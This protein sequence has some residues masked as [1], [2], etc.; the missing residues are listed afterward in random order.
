MSA[1]S[2]YLEPKVLDHTLGNTAYTQPTSLEIGLFTT[3]VGDDASG[4]EV[5][6]GGYARQTVTFN[7]AEQP[8]TGLTQAT[9]NG[10]VTFPTATGDYP[11]A[12]THL[13]IFD[14]SDNLLYHGALTQSKTVNTGDT[15]QIQDEQLVITLT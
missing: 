13:G 4:T 12:V 10:A 9:N 5:T 15:F 11:S 6:G 2:D 14:E 1:M 7:A 3:A 8:S